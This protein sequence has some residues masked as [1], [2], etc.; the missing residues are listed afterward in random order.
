MT[1]ITQTVLNTDNHTKTHPFLNVGKIDYQIF[2]KMVKKY[3]TPKLEK[4][5][6]ELMSIIHS[7]LDLDPNDE[8]FKAQ[9]I[10]QDGKYFLKLSRVK[11][12]GTNY[13]L[14]CIKDMLSIAD[15]V[16]DNNN[17]LKKVTGRPNLAK[18]DSATIKTGESL[19]IPLEDIGQKRHCNWRSWSLGNLKNAVKNFMNTA[20]NY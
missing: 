10:N 4:A 14:G 7:E 15:D 19:L 12:D 2:N 20:K 6:E 3:E 9:I 11:E 1:T 16:L 8:S 17:K 5:K 13:K 18:S